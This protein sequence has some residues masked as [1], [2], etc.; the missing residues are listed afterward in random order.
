[1]LKA[2]PIG[3]QR[4]L[5]RATGVGYEERWQSYIRDRKKCAKGTRDGA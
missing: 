3:G 4:N 5:P 1:M 2:A